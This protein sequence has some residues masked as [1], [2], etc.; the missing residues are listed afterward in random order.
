[1]E[2]IY[3]RA[4]NKIITYPFVLLSSKRYKKDFDIIIFLNYFTI[5]S[6]KVIYRK[7]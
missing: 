3:K 1:M 7:K 6:Q 4:R 2:R 5:T